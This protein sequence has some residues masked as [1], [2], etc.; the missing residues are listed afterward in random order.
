MTREEMFSAI[1]GIDDKLIQRSEVLTKKRSNSKIMWYGG[2]LA[3]AACLLLAFN[4]MRGDVLPDDNVPITDSYPMNQIGGNGPDHPNDYVPGPVVDDTASEEQAY[5]MNAELEWTDF[6][7]G[8]IMP[9]TF[10]DENK[11]IVA[12]RELIYDFSAVARADKGYVPVKDSYVLN[13][14]SET[15]QVITVYY[16]YVSNS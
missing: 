7:A 2:M 15:E 8:P 1:G 14:I 5:G 13:N 3:S 6:N 12:G 10:A 16:P 9:L 11:N 4:V